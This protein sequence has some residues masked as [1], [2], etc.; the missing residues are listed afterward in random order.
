MAKGRKG[1]AGVGLAWQDRRGE[2]RPGEHPDGNGRNGKGWDGQ[3]W[4]RNG[5]TGRE[6]SGLVPGRRGSEWSGWEG[7]ELPGKGRLDWSGSI[8]TE[9]RRREALA[10]DRMGRSGL[11]AMES[12]C[13][14]WTG[15]HRQDRK[16][17][18]G[19]GSERCGPAGKDRLRL[20]RDDRRG[21]AAIVWN[22]CLWQGKIGIGEAAG[23][24]KVSARIDIAGQATDRQQRIADV[25]LG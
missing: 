12:R 5:R 13:L 4:A 21:A 9:G 23:D 3:F 18:V 14:E 1:S 16:R 19:M 6:A 20:A 11:C 15:E 17:Q 8:G 24:W 22:G 10:E 2:V 25:G 7:M